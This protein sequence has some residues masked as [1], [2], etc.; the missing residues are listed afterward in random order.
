MG[1]RVQER[2]KFYKF[3][4]FSLQKNRLLLFWDVIQC[5]LVVC[6]Q[7]CGTAAWSHV[8]GYSSSWTAWPLKMGL[9]GY[10]KMSVTNYP[11]TPL[12]YNIP[13]EQR[14]HLYCGGNLKCHKRKIVFF[15]LLS[16]MSTFWTT[17]LYLKYLNTGTDV[18]HK[19]A[20]DTPVYQYVWWNNIHTDGRQ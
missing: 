12:S 8:L 9:I 19:I 4:Y 1:Q 20:N 2:C 7:C 5:T 3:R 16:S 13:N 14:P 10:P 11:H 6:Y 18:V 17:D 15:L